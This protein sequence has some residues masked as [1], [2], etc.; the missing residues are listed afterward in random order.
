MLLDRTFSTSSAAEVTDCIS[1]SSNVGISCTDAD[2][3]AGRPL[4]SGEGLFVCAISGL[5]P[6]SL[7][8]KI[9]DDVTLVVPIRDV[10]YN[11]N[12]R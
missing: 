2:F 6:A 10:D 9:L 12:F 8:G 5:T 4:P 7:R 1:F 3:T 11:V